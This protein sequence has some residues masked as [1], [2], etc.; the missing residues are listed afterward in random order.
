MSTT[1][2]ENAYG[3]RRENVH[4]GN[5]R[6]APWNTWAFRHISE[7]IPTARIEAASNIPEEPQADP[8]FLIRQELELDDGR[9]TI[10]EALR[11]TSTDALVVMKAG[12]FIADFHAPHFSLRSRHIL[13]SA[14]KSIAGVL[15]GILVSD[16]LLDPEEPVVRYVPEL[17]ASAFGDATVRDVLDMRTSLAFTENYL[18]PTGDFARY[19]RAGLLDPPIDGEKRESVI[20][21]LASMNKGKGPHGGPFY[22]S[23]P[24][25]D[26]LGLIV[27]RASGQRYADFA[28]E[29][30]WQPLEAR[31]DGY[32]TIDASGTARAG[33]GLFMTARDF[34]RIGEMMRL[35]GIVGGRRI[36]SADWVQDT[37]S[38]GDAEAWRAGSFAHWLPKGAYRN[39]W[40]QVRN[41]AGVFFALGI[42]GQCLY[43]NPMAEVVIAK[44]SSRPEPT[45]D[46]NRLLNFLLFDAISAFT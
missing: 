37:V 18:D 23:S 4:L 24:N 27:E 2:F 36:V 35:G 42:Y 9:R 20:E 11:L 8:S 19:R 5:W 21:F 33:G 30:L 41:A 14:S 46:R 44:F 22:Y 7:F 6:S 28:A 13:F 3:F 17:A 25:S 32:V 34:A 40:Y 26:V 45:N 31:Q 38:G 1:A 15:A 43:V 10:A 16:G 29:R 39:K 12:R